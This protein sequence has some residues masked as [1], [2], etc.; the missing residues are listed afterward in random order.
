M[1][2]DVGAIATPPTLLWPTFPFGMIRMNSTETR[3]SDIDQGNR[4]DNFDKLDQWRPLYQENGNTSPTGNYQI[5]FTIYSVPAYISSNPTDS[6]NFVS[7][8]AIPRDHAIP[9]AD[10]APTEPGTA[11]P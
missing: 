2:I 9:R 3:W 4:Q 1:H 11:R 10:D 6:C 7:T 8:G 5:V